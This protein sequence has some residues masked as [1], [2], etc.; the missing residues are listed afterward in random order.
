MVRSIVHD[1]MDVDLPED[2]EIEL[3]HDLLEKIMPFHDSMIN[4][5]DVCAELDC[6]LAFAEAARTFDYRRP[7][8]IDGSIIDVVQAR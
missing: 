6:L 1:S 2:R 8:M 3:V 7:Q 4:A 5:C